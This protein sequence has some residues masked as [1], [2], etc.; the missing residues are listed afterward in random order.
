MNNVRNYVNVQNITVT[1]VVASTIIIPTIVGA[2][3][4]GPIGAITG[5]AIGFAGSTATGIATNKIY[6][7]H[8]NKY[9]SILEKLLKEKDIMDFFTLDRQS[10]NF[11]SKKLKNKNPQEV[12]EIKNFLRFILN[13]AKVKTNEKYIIL[14]KRDNE[15]SLKLTQ[16]PENTA[17][18]ACI[19]LYIKNY[20]TNKDKKLEFVNM[21][22]L[23]NELGIVKM[24]DFDDIFHPTKKDISQEIQVIKESETFAPQNF[25]SKITDFFIPKRALGQNNSNQTQTANSTLNVTY[26]NFNNHDTII[27]NILLD[28]NTNMEESS[29]THKPIE[30]SSIGDSSLA[31]LP[32]LTYHELETKESSTSGKNTILPKSEYKIQC[33]ITGLNTVKNITNSIKINP[34]NIKQYLKM[35]IKSLS[36]NDD[37]VKFIISFQ[38]KTI[39]SSEISISETE[40][41]QNL[42]H[43]ITCVLLNSLNQLAD[44]KDKVII[45]NI[46]C[47]QYTK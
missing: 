7:K 34:T 30:L 39:V 13:E 37:G 44:Q 1:G 20:N 35:I 36:N 26:N 46:L 43:I 41:D 33:Q 22:R 19:R 21:I 14:D 38:D 47:P 42:I 8:K 9:H 40:R 24:Q 11:I 28:K 45:E 2:A 18:D 32:A 6:K 25:V 16:Y 3:I 15:D 4:A 5:G 12:K 17:K 29:L 10:I 31:P 27:N 23:L